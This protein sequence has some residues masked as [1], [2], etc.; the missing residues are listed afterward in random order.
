MKNCFDDVLF[1]RG[2]A[3]D[4]ISC[5][6]GI[7]FYLKQRGTKN[8][9]KVKQMFGLEQ[10]DLKT[11]WHMTLSAAYWKSNLSFEQNTEYLRLKAPFFS[12][13]LGKQ[14]RYNWCCFNSSNWNEG[15]AVILSLPPLWC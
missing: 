4:S 6:S 9:D 3:L 14:A 15:F 13:V 12:R 1:Q 11:V 7:G 10:A 2:I 5:V 8:T